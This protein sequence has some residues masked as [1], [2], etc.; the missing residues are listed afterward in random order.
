[1]DTPANIALLEQQK[2][3]ADAKLLIELG[4]E[5]AAKKF[6]NT[7]PVT[8]KAQGAALK[9]LAIQ[10]MSGELTRNEISGYIINVVT[11]VGV[12]LNKPTNTWSAWWIDDDPNNPNQKFA[13]G[14]DPDFKEMIKRLTY[15]ASEFSTQT[16]LPSK[17]YKSG[18][19]GHGILH[20]LSTGPIRNGELI[21]YFPTIN[22]ASTM[23]NMRRQ[24]VVAK[25]D[26]NNLQSPYIITDLGQAI[27]QE[28]GPYTF[29]M[30]KKYWG[31]TSSRIHGATCL[32]WE[33]SQIRE[34]YLKRHYSLV[35]GFSGC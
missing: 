24:G 7:K 3:E 27:L 5:L 35:D 28:R 14:L 15:V 31:I 21:S 29:A 22:G 30:W 19:I 2:N 16:T 1:V 18:S 26:D 25:K 32:P 17:L 9:R 4:R 10:L 6:L 20:A 8:L 13:Q 11:G 23:T 12:C 34:K 33:N